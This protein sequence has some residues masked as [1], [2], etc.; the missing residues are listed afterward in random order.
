MALT[1]QAPEIQGEEVKRAPAELEGRVDAVDNGRLF[2]WVWDAANPADRLAV[3]VMFDQVRIATVTADRP[4]IDLKRNGIGDGAYAFDI[5]IPE[6]ALAELD[7]LAVKAIAPGGE[8]AVLRMPTSSERVAEAAMT[9]PL[10]RI[11]DRLDRLI[12]AQRQLQKV[13]YESGRASHKAV[14]GLDALLSTDSG[15]SEAVG[16]V[17]KGHEGFASRLEE[18]DVFLM[19]FDASLKSFDDRLKALAERSK[20]DQRPHL[21]LLA[22]IVGLMCGIGLSLALF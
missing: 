20:N 22:A 11:L 21:F 7:R 1:D 14:E 4:R 17:R 13:Q 10:S 12:V 9:V 19:R 8:E 2:G 5:E 16:I 18:L 15:L 6:E 3:Q